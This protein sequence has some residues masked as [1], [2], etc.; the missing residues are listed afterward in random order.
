MSLDLLAKLPRSLGLLLLLCSWRFG[1]A[2]VPTAIKNAPFTASETDITTNADGTTR[3]AVG[4][5]ARRSD[6]STY[7]E[8]KNADGSGGILVT[9]LLQHRWF[10]LYLGKGVYTSGNS[11]AC[12]AERAKSFFDSSHEAGF[13]YKQGTVVITTSVVR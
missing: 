8:S 4:T 7:R 6:G 10:Q 9:D 3:L 13:T 1:A 5:V 2:Q 11:E 12:P